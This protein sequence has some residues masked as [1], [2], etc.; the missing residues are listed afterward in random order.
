MPRIHSPKKGTMQFW[1]RKRARRIFPRIKNWPSLSKTKIL[2]FIAYKAGMTHIQYY[3]NKPTSL[4]KNQI[5]TIP[6]T[7]L[8][9]PP[10]KTHSLRFYK[11]TP[12]GI[13][14][15]SEIKKS[16]EKIPE[17]FDDIKL[18]IKTQP[19]LT[20]IGKKIP[21]ILEIALSGNKD[22][23]LNLAKDLLQKEI[24]IN[25]VF[26]EGQ[27][28]D[29]HAVTQG[30]GFQGAVKRFGVKIRQHKSEKTKRGTGSLGAWTPKKVLFTVP[31][32]GKMG[33]HVRTEFNKWLLKIG[34]DPKFINLKGGF[35]HYGLI[36]NNYIL[37]KGSI[38]GPVKR[39]IVLTEPI[40]QPKKIP[41]L[42]EITYISLESKQ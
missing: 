25:D 20:G 30:K 9:T 21:E 34:N 13:K 23:K 35:L 1:P 6:V 4:T 22:E 24:K 18:I 3:D 33:Y 38:P 8:E 14:I 32:P 19:S 2:G 41:P 17:D 15:I 37:L 42:P 5:I 7:I 28:I 26:K 36:K 16:D 27:F 31:M 29:V 39:P 12:Y 11:K 10:I 40:R